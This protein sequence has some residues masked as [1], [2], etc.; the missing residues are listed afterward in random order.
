MKWAFFPFVAQHYLLPIS[1]KPVVTVNQI[2]QNTSKA[3]TTLL[4]GKIIA[5]IH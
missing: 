4:K 3:I 1:V 2:W 5:K